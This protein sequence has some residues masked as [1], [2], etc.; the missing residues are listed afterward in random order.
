[1]MSTL[2]EEEEEKTDMIDVDLDSIELNY[3]DNPSDPMMHGYLEKESLYFKTYRK[4]WIELRDNCLYSYKDENHSEDETEIVDLNLFEYIE[5]TKD[6]KFKLISSNQKTKRQFIAP[7][8]QTLNK[9][10]DQIKHVSNIQELAHQKGSFIFELSEAQ[11]LWNSTDKIWQYYWKSDGIK[12]THGPFSC[13]EMAKRN[14]FYFVKAEEPILFK[15]VDD[16]NWTDSWSV[17]LMQELKKYNTHKIPLQYEPE[18][19]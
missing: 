10:V 15:R 19:H 5:R 13:A 12:S 14:N 3:P 2:R 9:W 17:D 11:I 6:N 18:M 4:R 7:S 8:T 1:M 16:E